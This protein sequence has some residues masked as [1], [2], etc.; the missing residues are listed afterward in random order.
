MPVGFHHTLDL[1]LYA[2]NILCDLLDLFLCL[3]ERSPILSDSLKLAHEHV[4]GLLE[5]FDSVDLFYGHGLASLCD[6]PLQVE[7]GAY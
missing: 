2:L 6:Q 7:C 1:F 5:H 4:L 3:L